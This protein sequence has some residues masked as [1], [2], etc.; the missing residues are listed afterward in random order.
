M[1]EPPCDE[2]IFAP[3][4]VRACVRVCVCACVRAWEGGRKGGK[5][6]ACERLSLKERM[7]ARVCA[8]MDAEAG[9]AFSV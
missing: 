4:I 7:R 8:W 9:V 2:L 3:C 1:E 6:G 5:E